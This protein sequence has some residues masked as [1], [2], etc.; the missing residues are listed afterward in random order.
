M[1]QHQTLEEITNGDLHI[2]HSAISCYQNCSLKFFYKYVEGRK[3]ESVSINLIFGSSIHTAINMIC[4]SHKNTQIEPLEAITD[5]FQTCLTL[6]INNTEIPIIFSKT[7]ADLNSAISMGK[8]MLNVFYDNFNLTEEVVAVDLPL[9]AV[10][11]DENKQHT[12]Y[13]LVGVIDLLIKNNT[14]DLIVVDFKTSS[15]SMSQSAVDQDQQLTS[16]SYLL[17]TNKYITPTAS[18][19]CRFDV[20]LKTKEPKLQQL[21]T[22]RDRTHRRRFAR[23]TNMILSGID[24]K[25]FMPTVSWMCQ[26]CEYSIICKEW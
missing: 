17:A 10:L 20:L 25:I 8:T 16:Y 19:K 12:E 22:D 13:K 11:Y 21:Y 2:S 6:D 1:T 26:S 15:K 24:A 5:T 9:S 23:L 3:P 18:V 4:R 7:I 14:G